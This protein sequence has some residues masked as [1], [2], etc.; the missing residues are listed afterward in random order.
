MRISGNYIHSVDGGKARRLAILIGL[1]LLAA[2]SGGGHSSKSSG[3]TLPAAVAPPT[4]NLYEA[5]PGMRPAAAG[6]RIWTQF[7]AQT[8]K[9]EL[10]GVATSVW[11]ILYHS[12]DRE[13]HD[14]PVSGFV[15]V[16]AGH[17]PA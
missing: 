13:G 7:Y 3:T 15:V 6:T 2:C 1:C 12:R 9:R 11:L 5:P 8:A 10:F 14:I 16:P 4:G 17:A